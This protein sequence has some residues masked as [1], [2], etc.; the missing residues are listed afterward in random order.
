MPQHEPG[1]VWQFKRLLIFRI[2]QKFAAAKVMRL[3][4][5]LVEKNQ[6]VVKKGW[7]TFGR[8]F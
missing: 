2:L 1:K 3:F 4:R 8:F 7:L 6:H 5:L